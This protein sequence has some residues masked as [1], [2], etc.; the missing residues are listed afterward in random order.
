MIKTIIAITLLKLAIMQ[1]S[2]HDCTPE[3]RQLD[4]TQAKPYDVCGVSYCSDKKCFTDFKSQCAACKDEATLTVI[5]ATC[6]TVNS[7]N[8]GSGTAGS[9]GT[10]GTSTPSS[11]GNVSS[12]VNEPPKTHV[13][14]DEDRKPCP[15]YL[16]KQAQNP[17]CGLFDG[18]IQCFAYPCGQNYNSI[19]EACNNPQVYEVAEVSCEALRNPVTETKPAY[20]TTSSYAEKCLDTDRAVTSCDGYKG[21]AVCGYRDNC[22]DNCNDTFENHCFACWKSD[23]IYTQTG[24]CPVITDIYIPDE[25]IRVDPIIN[26]FSCKSYSEATDCSNDAI[27]YVCKIGEDGI[28]KTYNNRC[29]ACLNTKDKKESIVINGKCPEKYETCNEKQ[30]NAMCTME[31]MGVCAVQ[32]TVNSEACSSNC[33]HTAGTICQACSDPN[34]ALVFSSGACEQVFPSYSIPPNNIYPIAVDNGIATDATTTSIAKTNGATSTVN[35]SYNGEVGQAT[36]TGITTGNVDKVYKATEAGSNNSIALNYDQTIQAAAAPQ[37]NNGQADNAL[38]QKLQGVICT[39]SDKTQ[40]CTSAS[41]KVCTYKKCASGF[42]PE[43]KLNKCEACHDTNTLFYVPADCI[44]FS[45]KN[46]IVPCLP[47]QR[48]I[49]D[50]SAYKSTAD[51]KTCGK[52][53]SSSKF[54]LSSNSTCTETF[55]SSC[56]ACANPD[57]ESYENNPCN[58]SSILTLTAISLLSLLLIL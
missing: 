23:I 13:C 19:C 55:D 32:I 58:S 12:S 15:N 38:S 22:K 54:C 53:S 17:I 37:L 42:C 16:V 7:P 51:T 35:A 6:Q 25:P 30:R 50:C 41:N 26:D 9:T 46:I 45:F 10:S 2:N 34:V 29:L 33:I 39:E 8:A 49:N 18:S 24:K 43:S 4:C 52:F 31:Y 20:P 57:I 47:D 40:V 48:L 1:S 36:A 27:E 28:P 21:E 56:S 44:N 14:S 11:G 3:D 5:F